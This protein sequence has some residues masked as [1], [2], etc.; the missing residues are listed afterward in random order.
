MGFV[1]NAN[2]YEMVDFMLGFFGLD[3]SGDDG[4]PYGKW[5]WQTYE[6]ANKSMSEF[7]SLREQ[8]FPDLLTTLPPPSAAK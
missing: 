3:I 2:Y 7:T 5:W 6:E 4:T 1:G 8:F